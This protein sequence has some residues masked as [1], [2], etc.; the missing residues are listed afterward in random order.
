VKI[1]LAL[2]SCLLLLV[3]GCAEMPPSEISL[4][5]HPILE[6][7]VAQAPVTKKSRGISVN[8]V[9]TTSISQARIKG[10]ISESCAPILSWYGDE[11]AINGKKRNTTS[12]IH[13]GFDMAAKIG[14]PV[15]AAAPGLVVASL[16]QPVSGNVIWVYHGQDRDSN[17][18]YSYSAHLIE[19]AVHKGRQVQRGELIGRSG[20]TGSGVGSEGAHLHFGVVMRAAEEFTNHFESLHNT[21]PA[22]PNHFLF[23]IDSF[24]HM[25]VVPS[26][27]PKWISSFDYGDKDW[28][29]KKL[30]TGFTFPMRCEAPR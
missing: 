26:Y 28:A 29:E 13:T 14:T 30:L 9:N 21:E 4:P 17:Q 7:K 6:H 3:V 18:I 23:P 16:Y 22:S 15:I 25:R 5:S 12:E 27:F 1:A 24:M 11:F 8:A 10:P 20:N 2:I 19:R